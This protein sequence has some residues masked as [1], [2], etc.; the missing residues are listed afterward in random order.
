MIN[1]CEDFKCKG[2]KTTISAHLVVIKFLVMAVFIILL[3][4]AV[5]CHFQ[6]TEANYY[7]KHLSNYESDKSGLGTL[8]ILSNIRWSNLLIYNDEQTGKF[9]KEERVSGNDGN[10][11]ILEDWRRYYV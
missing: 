6:H 3:S 1:S 5:F 9:G 11:M 10:N 8:K 4:L 7:N 2:H